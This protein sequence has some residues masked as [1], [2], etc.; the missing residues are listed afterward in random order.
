M[1]AKE[2]V[3]MPHRGH[4]YLGVETW[5]MEHN[6]VRSGSAMMVRVWGIGGS[7]AVNGC[8]TDRD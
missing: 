4:L 8:E 3:R 6:D 7:E 5:Q 1:H 2:H